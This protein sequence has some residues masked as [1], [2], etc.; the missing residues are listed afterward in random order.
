MLNNVFL[1]N[2]FINNVRST[3]LDVKKEF[4]SDVC[5]GNVKKINSFVDVLSKGL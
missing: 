4:I 2:E 5:D 3:M 1:I